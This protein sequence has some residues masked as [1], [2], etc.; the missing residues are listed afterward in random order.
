MKRINAL[1]KKAFEEQGFEGFLIVNEANMLYFSGFTGAA[2][3]LISNRSENQLYV[4]SVNYEQAKAEV[5]GFQVKLVK[6]DENIMA[7]VAEQVK[8]MEIKKLAFDTL[9][10]ESYAVLSKALRGKTKLRMR[11]NLI[12]ELRKVKDYDEL[13]LMRK[14]A[15]LTVEGM[16]AASEFVKPGVKEFEVAAEIEYAMRRKGS[17]GTAFD[18]IVASGPRSAFPHGGCTEREIREGDLVVVDIGATYK[19]YRSDMTRTFVAGKPSE[20]QQRLY[21]LVREAQEKAIKHVKAGVNAKAVDAAARNVIEDAGYGDFFVHGLGHGIGL[22]VHEPPTLSPN[23]KDRL[24]EGNVVTVE[25]GIYIVGYGG[26]RI[27]DAVLVHGKG[28]EKLTDGF[29]L[30]DY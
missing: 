28:C 24:T 9:K 5:E 22:E 11:S 25:P 15:E 30:S 12:W 2:A 26:I 8:A 20:R 19:H 16:K 27:E 17:W 23:S 13:T 21:K 3:L 1:R 10:V 29:Y 6:G 18:T 14:A 7:K 4:Y